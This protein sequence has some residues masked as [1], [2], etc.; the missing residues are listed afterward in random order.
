MGWYKSFVSEALFRDFLIVGQ[1]LAGSALAMS[2][3]EKGASVWVVDTEQWGA[4]SEVAAG[5]VTPL[6][7]KGMNPGWRQ[8]EYLP[9]AIAYYRDLEKQY[10]KTL[11]YS[12]PVV[13]PFKGTQEKEKF[14]NSLEKR[15][16]WLG[17]D[18]ELPDELK[19]EHGAFTMREGGW[20][21]TSAYL[22]LIRNILGEDFE[23]NIVHEE[24]LE[25]LDGAVK[26]RGKRF[27]KVI[28]CGGYKDLLEGAFSFLKSRS[29]KGEMLRVRIDGLEPHHIFSRNGWLVPLPDGSW[30]AGASY[31]W[32][33]L[34]E[35]LSGAGRRD[36]EE[37][38]QS[39]L[40]LPYEVIEQ[41]AGV[42][43]IVNNSQP[44]VGLHPEYPCL[45]MFNGLGSKGVLTSRS[46]ALHFADYLLGRIELD[47]ELNYTRLIK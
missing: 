5:L 27:K 28:F 47:P 40:S 11:F 25:M 31:S 20:L 8:E 45:G 35:N 33:D 41:T 7:G 1:G 26:W 23:Q 43:P 22:E 38:I 4:A 14:Q 18:A 12:L 30:R 3:R 15:K 29:A 44:V 37:R 17:E 39:L 21:D 13:R 46:V 9:E 24:D 42:R 32:D 10:E 19:A 36:V 2:L 34:N 16:A 6:A